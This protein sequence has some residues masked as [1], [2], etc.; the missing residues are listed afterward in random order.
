MATPQP[1]MR[2]TRP[3]NGGRDCLIDLLLDFW[4]LDLRDLPVDELHG[5]LDTVALCILQLLKWDA[6][7]PNTPLHAARWLDIVTTRVAEEFPHYPGGP[8]ELRDSLRRSMLQHWRT[9]L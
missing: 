4:L 9:S 6:E 5:W 8:T 1:D 2:E 7:H 3:R